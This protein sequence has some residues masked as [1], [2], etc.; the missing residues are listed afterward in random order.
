MYVMHE[1]VVKK[2]FWY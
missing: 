2:T 1:Q